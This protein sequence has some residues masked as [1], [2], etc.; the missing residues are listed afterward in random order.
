MLIRGNAQET[1]PGDILGTWQV[2]REL[3][4]GTQDV[5]TLNLKQSGLDVTGTY[6]S[7]IG[8]ATIGNGKLAEASL[9]F[10]MSLVGRQLEVTGKSLTNNKMELTSAARS[11]SQTFRAVAEWPPDQR[12]G[13]QPL[14]LLPFL[15]APM[16]RAPLTAGK[17]FDIY[18]HQTFSPSALILPA[19]GAGLSMLNP[20]SQYP[21]EWKDGAQAFGRE[22]GNRVAT[23][24]ARDTA[25]MLATVI[26]HEDPRYMRSG[27][28]NML[29]RSFHAL[30]YTVLDR[31]D[32]GRRTIAVSNFAGAAAGGLVAIGYLPNGYNDA[33]HAGQRMAAQFAVVAIHNL[34]AEFQPQWG[35]IV[36]KL[37]IPK[38]L[39]E[40]WVPQHR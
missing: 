26:L 3:K 34:A 13:G 28:T 5:S 40:W 11:M 10:S 36:R 12:A 14:S 16:T 15:P 31:T 35:S 38:P 30:S 17:K 25:S 39:P 37:R 18:V 7:S 20:P 29:Y 23:A 19:F 2:T 9:T 22:Y 1:S 6:S 4:D 32:S 21:R 27:S 8:N 24:S 33:T